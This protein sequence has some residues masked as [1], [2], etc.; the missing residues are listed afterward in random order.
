MIGAVLVPAAVGLFSDHAGFLANFNSYGRHLGAA[1]P[2]AALVASSNK[3][4]FAHAGFS[5]SMTLRAVSVFWFIFGFIF[6]S[7]YFAGEIR[8]AKRTHIYLDAGR[9]AAG[10]CR[11]CCSSWFRPSTTSSAMTSA[12]RL[13]AG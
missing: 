3:A 8:L 12:L 9:G 2:V 5:W 4:G 1:H 10:W 11:S 7:N 13:G 6:S